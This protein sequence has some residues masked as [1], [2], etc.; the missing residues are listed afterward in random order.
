MN[1][2]DCFQAIREKV[3]KQ[4][5]DKKRQIVKQCSILLIISLTL[6]GCFSIFPKP[7]D[8]P[9]L[10]TLTSKS[11]FAKELPQVKGLIIIERPH[12]GADIETEKITVHLTPHKVDYY[13]QARW[14][15]RGHK[16]MQDLMV[17]SFENSKKITAIA[18]DSGKLRADYLLM[19]ELKEF[20]AESYG[21]PETPKVHVALNAK[22]IKMPER[23]LI[24]SQNF[25]RI[26][27]SPS[28]KMDDIVST[29]DKATSNVL[30]KL[31]NWTIQS[32]ADYKH[33]H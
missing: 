9:R 6:S 15:E 33:E 10:Y 25:D 28:K 16:M 21:S 23:K 32:I 11:S 2:L 31:V 19:S 30:K 17:E 20:Q 13:K 14:I 12:V 1:L 4:N 22:L 7:A 24:T 26:L 8:P 29:F 18:S 27:V 5:K 3:L